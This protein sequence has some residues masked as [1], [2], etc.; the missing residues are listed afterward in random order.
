MKAKAGDKVKIITQEKEYEGIL[1]PNEETE[2]IVVK[3]GSGYNIGIDNKKIK[4]IEVLKEYK[5]PKIQKEKM[6][7]RDKNKKTIFILHTGGTIAS[8]VDYNTGGVY[9]RF[10]PDEIVEMFPELLKIANIDSW[11]IDNMW[12]E[13][14]RF[15]HYKKMAR[16]VKKSIDKGADGVII[17]HG[18]D[19]MGYSAAALAFILEDINVPVILVGAQRSSDRGSSDAAI[20]LICAAEFII[21][22]DFV[23]VG[24]CMHKNSDDD[25]CNILPACKTRKM[26]S[27]RRDAFKPINDKAIA[28]IDFNTKKIS[29]LK[30]DYEKKSK[31]R[32]LKIKDN[33]EENVAILKCYPNISYKQFEFF[34][35]YKGLVIEAYALG[36]LPID[37]PNKEAKPNLKNKKALQEL[38]DSGCIVTITS[39]CVFGKVH[40]HVYSK[41]IEIKNMGAIY[42][43]D[44]LTETAFIKLAWLLGNYKKEEV[45]DK[46]SE[47]LRGEI[48]ERIKL[49][50]FLYFS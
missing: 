47:N 5:E 46:I 31:D 33:F 21:R 49:D 7:G 32:K 2:S 12:S 14:M 11:L 43:Q 1:M 16:H 26:H 20:N 13:D 24:I 28:E 42:L 40:P 23:G 44:M 18:T 4:K 48:N 39:Q 50:E 29:F 38:I 19:T 3:L 41:A 15:E 25:I 10:T 34:K 36:Q 22:T 30:K 17:T 27:S 6:I 35:G 9:A 8:K 45:K 37:A